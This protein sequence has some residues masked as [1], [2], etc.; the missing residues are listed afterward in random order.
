MTKGPDIVSSQEKA[1]GDHGARTATWT[2]TLQASERVS[3]ARGPHSLLATKLALEPSGAVAEPLGSYCPFFS[4]WPSTRSAR[5]PLGSGGAK[6]QSTGL[7][8]CCVF[9]WVQ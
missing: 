1:I 6:F 4:P 8:S 5:Q 9:L 3:G 7:R 2:R